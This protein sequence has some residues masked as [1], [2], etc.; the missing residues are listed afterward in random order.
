MF[1]GSSKGQQLY[2]WNQGQDYNMPWFW[3]QAKLLY[4][5][6]GFTDLKT[7]LGKWQ[8]IDISLS[9]MIKMIDF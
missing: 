1:Y 9:I 3:E 4:G 8:Y 6:D 2:P 7:W 5:R